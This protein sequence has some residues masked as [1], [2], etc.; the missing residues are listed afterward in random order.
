MNRQKVS[1]SNIDAIGYD[2]GSQ[3]LEIE[4]KT[5]S[6]YQYSGVAAHIYDGFLRATSKGRFF[7]QFVRNRFQ[8][9][10]VR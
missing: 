7:D 6:I 10:R 1:S 4:F 5:G 3:T 8:T 9:H 2:E